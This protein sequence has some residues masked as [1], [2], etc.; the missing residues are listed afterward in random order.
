MLSLNCIWKF[1]QPMWNLEKFHNNSSTPEPLNLSPFSP[2]VSFSTDVLLLLAWFCNDISHWWNTCHD[3][4][5]ILHSIPHFGFH[6]R[7]YHCLECFFV[8]FLPFSIC[9]LPLLSLLLLLSLSS[10]LIWLNDSLP[11]SKKLSWRT[12][13]NLFS[14]YDLRIPQSSWHPFNCISVCGQIFL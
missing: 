3:I 1:S 7:C 13:G 14:K 8:T 10:S 11:P 9:L 12:S 2:L 6:H 5:H 4:S